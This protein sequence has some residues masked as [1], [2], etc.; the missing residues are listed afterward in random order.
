[1]G[2]EPA[3]VVEHIDDAGFLI[4]DGDRRSPEPET[5]DFAGA[6]EIEGRVEFLLGHEPHADAAGDAALRLAS[7]PHSTAVLFDKLAHGDAERQ[8]DAA[9]L[10]DMA[11][12]AVKLGPVAAGVARILRI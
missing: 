7:L 11:G 5:T 2:E 6:V 1:M 8:F 9:W 12:D 4:E 3:D 10:V